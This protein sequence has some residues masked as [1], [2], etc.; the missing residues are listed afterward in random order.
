MYDKQG[1]FFL[2]F[3]H[4]FIFVAFLFY[5]FHLLFLFRIP[6]SGTITSLTC[7]YE[8][9][10]CRSVAVYVPTADGSGHIHCQTEL[11]VG[12]GPLSGPG[13]THQDNQEGGAQAPEAPSHPDDPTDINKLL[14]AQLEYY[15]SRSVPGF[16]LKMCLFIH[17]VQGT[18]SLLACSLFKVHALQVKG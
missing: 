18:F 10:T 16:S 2:S 3:F 17:S 6:Y 14:L 13:Q 1:N 12:H 11:Y 15:F 7:T 5:V 8:S 4:S 9:E